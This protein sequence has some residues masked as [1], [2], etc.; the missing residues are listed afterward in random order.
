[1][2]STSLEA[3]LSECSAIQSFLEEKCEGDPS[4]LIERLA[5]MNSYMARSGAL[6]AEAKY[7]QDQKRL[8]GFE[9]M[10]DAL[11]G[12]PATTINRMVESLSAPENFAVNW[13]D[14]INRGCVHQSDNLRTLISF[15]KEEM[16]LRSNGY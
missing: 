12:F 6:L 11:A 15:S 2:N 16:R 1:M 14:R 13:L 7:M 8:T 4:V 3:M 5:D 9:A 10:R